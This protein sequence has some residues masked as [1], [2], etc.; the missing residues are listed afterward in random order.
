MYHCIVQGFR[1][2]LTYPFVGACRG[3]R[4]ALSCTCNRCTHELELVLAGTSAGAGAQTVVNLDL[5]F[6]LFNFSFVYRCSDFTIAS[7]VQQEPAEESGRASKDVTRESARHVGTAGESTCAMR[8]GTGVM[9]QGPREKTA[10]GAR[11]GSAGCVAM[12]HVGTTK[13][14]RAEQR[15]LLSRRRNPQCFFTSGVIALLAEFFLER[16]RARS[17][18]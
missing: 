1:L 16:E 8:E 6:F 12:Q 7:L 9:A 15:V 2:D 14:I 4:E 3:Q 17:M 13:K 10:Q 5:Q 18:R 11:R